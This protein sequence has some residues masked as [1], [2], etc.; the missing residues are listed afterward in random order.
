MDDLFQL[1]QKLLHKSS[2]PMWVKIRS[3]LAEKGIDPQSSILVEVFPDDYHLV[4]GLIITSD[5]F[6]YKFDYNY[7]ER[8]VD[9]GSFSKWSDLSDNYENTPY[10][11]LI[12]NA[13]RIKSERTG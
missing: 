7:R 10:A 12:K 9:D 11:K 1:K 8:A 13:L 2:D 6:V 3:L 5:N 4:F